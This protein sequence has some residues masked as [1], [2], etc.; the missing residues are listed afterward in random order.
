M[1]MKLVRKFLQQD[2]HQLTVDGD[3]SAE[4]RKKS[5]KRRRRRRDDDEDVVAATDQE[6]MQATVDSMVYLDRFMADKNDTK[7]RAMK[8]LNEESKKAKKS[9]KKHLKDDAMVGNSRSSSSQIRLPSQPTFNKKKYKKE[10]EEK[11]L[12]EIAKLFLSK[13]KKTSK[14]I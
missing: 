8:R 11:R 12:K 5:K 13:K 6:I 7:N 14:M 3:G 9:R 4:K 10:Q 2:D 1:S